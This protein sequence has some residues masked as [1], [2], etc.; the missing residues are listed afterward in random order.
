MKMKIFLIVLFMCFILMISYIKLNKDEINYTLLGD[1]EIFSN[2]IVSKN[3][4]D[5]IYDEIK[6]NNE[7]GFYSKDF[8]KENVRIIDVIN[9]I[10]NNE[11]INNI[12]IQNIL[13][14]TNILIINIGNNEI[15]YKLSKLDT[16]QNNDKEVYK[17]LDDVFSDLK[18]LLVEIKKYDKKSV[19]ILGYFNDTNN[20]NN[21]KYYEYINN[22]VSVYSKQ[23]NLEFINLQRILNKNDDYITKTVPVYVTNE[24]NLAMFNKIY[25][26]IVNIYLHKI[27]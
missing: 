10:Q 24:G 19:I 14:R 4:A 25:N 26:K 1:S 7:F 16:E 18:E 12:A 15:N 8:I 17:Y 21:D 27:Y 11:E 20:S 13:K 3:F 5:L 9:Q 2:N 22:K 23:N 6:D